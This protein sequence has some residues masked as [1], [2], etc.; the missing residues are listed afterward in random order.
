MSNSSRSEGQISGFDKS[1][2][3]LTEKKEKLL[4]E[5]IFEDISNNSQEISQGEIRLTKIF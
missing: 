3:N 5:N 4:T 2:E 1:H